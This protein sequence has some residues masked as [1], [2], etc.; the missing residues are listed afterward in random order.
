MEVYRAEDGQSELEN[1][2]K[3][4]LMMTGNDA[5]GDKRTREILSTGIICRLRKWIDGNITRLIPK[6]SHNLSI[7]IQKII[8]ISSNHD[9][10]KSKGSFLITGFLIYFVLSHTQARTHLCSLSRHILL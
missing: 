2:L 6:L 3:T 4:R 5:V 9:Q 1:V 7:F 8:I 10:V